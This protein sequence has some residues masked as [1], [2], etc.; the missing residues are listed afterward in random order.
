MTK[1]RGFGALI[2]TVV[3]LF[4]TF[5]VQS[6]SL[7]DFSKLNVDEL[8]NEQV[9]LLFSRAAA[10]GYSQSDLFEL[11][12]QQGLSLEDIGK[13]NSRYT[14][15]RNAERTA[16][17]TKS[18]VGDRLRTAYQDSLKS[19]SKRN[20]DI[21]GLDYFSKN[22]VFLTFEPSVNRPTPQGY[23]LGAGDVIFIDIYGKSEQYYEAQ[24]NP[25][26]N[27]ILENVGPVRVAGLSIKESKERLL[28]QLAVFYK[29]LKGESP[30]TY[31]SV[32]LGQTRAITVSVVGQVELPG[33]YSLS[34]FS[35][36]L[37]AL[38]VSGG[39]S[40]NGTLRNVKVVRDE[41]L[42]GTIDLYEFLVDGKV[43]DNV[44]LQDDDV[45][46]VGPYENRV[47]LQG[48]VK[49]PARFE[50]KE[51][52][53]LADLLRYAG[54]FREDAY[55]TKINLTRNQKGERAVAD[56]FEEQYG[57]F[58]TQAG[59]VYL[60]DQVLDRYANRVI[61]KGAV[62]RPGD[63]AITEGLTVKQLI[64]RAEGLRPDA[65]MGRAYLLRTTDELNIETLSF[66]LGR[67]MDGSV[68][69]ITLQSDDVLNIV[70]SND[71]SGE[72]YVEISGEVNN[73]GVFAFSKGM[74][75][76]DLILM[77][78]G[79]RE[80]GTGLRAEVT[81]RISDETDTD[82]DLS[83]VLVA[84]LDRN[85]NGENDMAL[86]AF[87][88]VVIR[89]NP[90]FEV[91]QFVAVEGQVNFPGQ[92]GIKNH[93]ER[94]SDLLKRAGGLDPYAFVEGATLIRRTEF[95][96]GNSEREEKIANLQQLRSRLLE[97]GGNLTEAEQFL[98]AR[99]DAEL[100]LLGTNQDT[101]QELSDFAKKDRLEEILQ[102]NSF[103]GEVK[104]KQ[105]EAI[106]IDLAAILNNPG[107]APDLLLE[108][109]D[110]LIV[111]RK[112]ETVS[113]RGK[114]LYPT[115]V[116]FEPGRTLKFYINSAGGFDNRAKRNGT[117]VI[118]ANGRVARTRK[119]LFF[120]NFPKVEAGA[121]IIVPAKPIKPPVAV[122][123]IIGITSG[124]AT[125]AFVI[126]QINNNGTN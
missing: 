90:N 122:Q 28:N 76:Y 56:V 120:R 75:I 70:S 30:N 33:T 126:S 82:N 16:R 83:D 104:V 5:Q 54:G 45:I 61:V 25:D 15:I 46:I 115:T 97:N 32:S 57:L 69:D 101:N 118:Y 22:S 31:L 84:D 27:I 88:H 119:F 38:Y 64:D 49:T 52:E 86:K 36:V 29:G 68:A 98:L 121:E 67:L 24:V 112:T 87:D 117:Y 21:F 95:F 89:R 39:V 96:E 66:D 6:Q 9:Q 81:R 3:L 107:S 100:N 93:G 8:S 77:A 11:A 78:Q 12:Q 72:Q 105:V 44:L 80:S 60:V 62:Y 59:D 108:E 73:P 1:K 91:Q 43:K 102:R 63:F 85:F 4:L 41:K 35:T 106:G 53:T 37:S 58:T 10:M 50:L 34:G 14:S 23:K 116:R 92:Y 65:F 48:A 103:L 51:G 110:I 74:G 125:L 7:P 79:Y 26:G 109:G 94:I 13:L 113:L 114:L 47:S 42:L 18:P 123:E 71:L 40:E 17:A 111:P 99:I 19:I 55:T 20:T 124:L 2:I